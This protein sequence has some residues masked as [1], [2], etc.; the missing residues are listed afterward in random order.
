[1]WLC[2]LA[3]L[4]SKYTNLLQIIAKYFVFAQ[5]IYK[6]Y[7]KTFYRMDFLVTNKIIYCMLKV[8]EKVMF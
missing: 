2:I 8:N 4:K 3:Y 6:Q 7:G 1:M 5:N